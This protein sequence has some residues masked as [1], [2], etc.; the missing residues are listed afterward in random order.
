MLKPTKT[1]ENPT[2]ISSLILL[3]PFTIITSYVGNQNRAD[4]FQMAPMFNVGIVTRCQTESESFTTKSK[5]RLSKER[6]E[7]F[8]Q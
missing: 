1:R 6:W 4:I 5:D 2:Q 3:N 7:E 8:K